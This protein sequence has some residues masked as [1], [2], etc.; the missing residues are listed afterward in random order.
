MGNQH[1][2]QL[3]Q[4]SPVSSFL[5]PFCFPQTFSSSISS[6]FSYFQ[7]PVSSASFPKLTS[8]HIPSAAVNPFILSP[9]PPSNSST[10]A[11]IRNSIPPPAIN[12]SPYLLHRHHRLHSHRQ[13]AP[14]LN[15]I[16]RRVLCSFVLLV[17]IDFFL[18]V[19]L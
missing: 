17:S 15:I 13:T 2:T 1:I 9:E 16:P 19:G 7:Q 12:P 8:F 3:F 14:L 11:A 10:A 5:P 6:L 4:I 18:S